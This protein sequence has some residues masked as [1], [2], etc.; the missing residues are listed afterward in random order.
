MQSRAEPR[1][2]LPAQPAAF[3]SSV[4]SSDVLERAVS[5]YARGNL[6]EAGQLFQQLHAEAPTARTLRSL[7]LVAFREQRFEDA[8]ALLEASLASQVK[9]LTPAQRQGAVTVLDEAR[10]SMPATTADEL[11]PVK[12]IAQSATIEESTSPEA[13]KPAPA[14][15]A[16]QRPAERLRP[17]EPG[18]RLSRT[19]YALLGLTGAALI[20][21]VSSY[22]TAWSRVSA[23]EDHCRDLPDQRCQVSDVRERERSGNIERL[24]R[25][26]LSSVVVAGLSG[27]AAALTLVWRKT[28]QQL[29]PT[30]EFQLGWRGTF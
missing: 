10:T 21:G 12:A 19:R 25:L 28:D 29:P 17:T 4:A 18:K 15:E 16:E 13:E 7:G 27:G 9:P 14:P 23:I 1:A 3:E 5:A 24:S 6:E 30:V 2:A 26:A 20:V 22:L 11:A 8:V